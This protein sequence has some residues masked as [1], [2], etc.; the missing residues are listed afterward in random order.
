MPITITPINTGF[1]TSNP[2]TYHYHHSVHKFYPNV[3]DEDK[4]LP[5]YAFLLDTG[6]ELILVD[7]GMADTDRANKYHHPGSLQ[8]DD[9]A[10]HKALA[11]RGYSC[12]DITKIVF[13]HLHWDHTFYMDKFERAAFY[14]QEDEYRFAMDSIPPYY[15]SYESVKL[16]IHPPFEG[17]EDRFVLLSG[18]AEIVPGVRVFRTPGHSVGHQ[19][20]EV[21]TQDGTYILAG[22]AIFLLDNLRE[23]PELGY[24]V[25]PPARFVDFVSWWNSAVEIKRRASSL[26]MVLGTH[27][28]EQVERFE[29]TPVL[30]IG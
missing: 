12:G 18:E 29:K 1:C 30:G 17:L 14:V 20:V 23:V 15:K 8:K 28:P 16:G 21:D 22:D 27:V 6:N 7:T 13:T 5:V 10:I 26:D 4:A 9:E 2:K 25:T 3:S 24:E 11:K 19:S